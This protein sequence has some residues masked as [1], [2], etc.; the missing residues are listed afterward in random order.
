MKN[1]QLFIL[2]ILIMTAFQSCK[3]F[4]AAVESRATC[5]VHECEMKVARTWIKYGRR[6]MKTK[7]ESDPFEYPNTKTY[8][9]GGCMVRKERP[10]IYKYY[11]CGQCQQLAKE[12][13][14]KQ[15]STGLAKN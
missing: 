8:H 7:L 5:G 11:Y 2:A 14:K 4:D 12:E 10:R 13:S 6:P 3:T 9:Y 15:K 1:L